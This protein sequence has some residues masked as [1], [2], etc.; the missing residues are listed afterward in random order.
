MRRNAT[1]TRQITRNTVLVQLSGCT[2]HLFFLSQKNNVLSYEKQV[3]VRDGV[4]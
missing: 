1:V 2:F 3:V 4:C